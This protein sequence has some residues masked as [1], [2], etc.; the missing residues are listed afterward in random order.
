MN[1]S[2]NKETTRT[3]T[4]VM[5]TAANKDIPV[6]NGDNIKFANKL[7][8]KEIT[9]RKIKKYATTTFGSA[10]RTASSG[11]N[12]GGTSDSGQGNF[13]SPQLS[14]DFLEKPQNLRERRAWYRHFY[15][16]NEFVGQ[17]IDLHS[18]LPLSKIRLEKPQGANQEQVDY[19]YS[20]F[21]EMCNETKLFKSLLEISH[22]YNLL[23]NC[24]PGN[25]VIRTKEGFKTID[26]ICVGDYVLTHKGR[27]KKVTKVCSRESD[28]DLVHIDVWKTYSPL[29][30]TEEHPVEVLRGGA[31]SFVEAKDI[32]AEDFI[33][34][35][36][37]KNIV[38]IDYVDISNFSQIQKTID[39]YNRK[40][41]IHRKRNELAFEARKKFVSW[42]TG[43]EE[44]VV[45]SRVEISEDLGIALKTLD[46]LVFQIGVEIGNDFHKR[47]G[48][49]GYQK[50]SR[51]V[52]YP[53]AHGVIDCSEKYFLSRTNVHVA[54]HRLEINDSFCYL[55]GYW[56]GDGTL[57]TDS[58]R[59]AWGRGLWQ[60][61]GAEKSSD[62]LARVENI[63][64]EMFGI[65]SIK[66]WTDSNGLYYVKV[67]N[68]PAF[69]EWW[70]DNF[71]RSY[72]NEKVKKI[73]QW[74]SELPVSKLKNFLAGIIDSDGCSS[75]TTHSNG[76]LLK[77][78]MTS[79]T[80][81]DVIREI[82]FKCGVIFNYTNKKGRDNLVPNG[83]LYHTA[84]F[85]ELTTYDEASCK[86]LTEFSCKKIKKGTKFLGSHGYFLRAG[87]DV[88]FK[89]K[90]ISRDPAETV[91]N[92]EVEDDHTYQANGFST[93]NCFIFAEDHEPY[94]LDDESKVS[95]LK[96]KGKAEAERLFKEFKIY[97]RDPNYKG[98]RKLIVLPPDQIRIKKI[99]LSDESMIE[100][101][102]DP[103]TRK[104]ILNSQES[105]QFGSAR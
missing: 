15:H 79:K 40:V 64:V 46:S 54:P 83:K 10:L 99:P 19:M 3:K 27:W 62:S 102:P 95:L 55:V 82:S 50:G 23:G 18:T 58:S 8:D 12:S 91:Y 1:E 56:L 43:L 61:C 47:L 87:D 33:R 38:D 29:V 20:F 53:V 68:N 49:I 37:P 41:V 77:I 67:N 60:I 7:T 16:S 42:I 65:K 93:H 51:V 71:G 13:Y 86:I 88:A 28:K 4:R 75:R 101:V 14:T 9:I 97:D 70:S 45:K 6:R 31:F 5:K 2:T 44:P 21:V 52:W 24:L 96:E 80:L 63:L 39:G 66:K 73:P 36:W 69:N 48:S 89:V 76:A 22:D 103:E 72:K 98:W 105:A 34:V 11:Y 35:T 78:G 59:K 100:F 90:T 84:N 104:S 25:S 74:F 85:Y 92:M 32:T 30:S 26:K 81:I 17:A 94:D 57:G